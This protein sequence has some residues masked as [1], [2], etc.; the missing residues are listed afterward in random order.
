MISAKK[1]RV[2]DGHGHVCA[3]TGCGNR[4]TVAVSRG[5]AASG[6]VY[7][8]RGCITEAASG[9]RKIGTKKPSVGI[10]DMLGG[11]KE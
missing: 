9:M 11:D 2:R 10:A 8:C 3:V 4:D 5:S 6:V 7:L 1:L